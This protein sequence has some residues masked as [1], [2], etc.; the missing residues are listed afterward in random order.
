[1]LDAL[2]FQALRRY[3]FHRV[4]I[5]RKQN[6]HRLAW[7]TE[8]DVFIACEWQMKCSHAD[9][10]LAC[11][12][13]NQNM[14]KIPWNYEIIVIF[15][16]ISATADVWAACL[17]LLKLIRYS[18]SGDFGSISRDILGIYGIICRLSSW[19]G[20][21][22][23]LPYAAPDFAMIVSHWMPN[24]QHWWMDGNN[25]IGWSI[26]QIPLNWQ[27]ENLQMELT[28]EKHAHSFSEC[29]AFHVKIRAN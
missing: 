4:R 23:Q 8:N 17:L 14:Q 11:V 12:A 27:R 1:M 10:K 15:F 5:Y 2:Y 28:D 29:F 9:C 21:L 25:C 26:Y 6:T 20:G 3:C 16:G 18:T 19:A 7:R 22:F 24:E 13:C